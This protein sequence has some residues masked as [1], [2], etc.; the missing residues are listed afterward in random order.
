[1]GAV[2]RLYG[3]TVEQIWSN[4]LTPPDTF[5]ELGALQVTGNHRSASG[6]YS[7]R[8]MD[9]VAWSS[10]KGPD[11][12]L[13][14]SLLLVAQLIREYRRKRIGRH[15]ADLPGR[16]YDFEPLARGRLIF[17][18]ERSHE[19]HAEFFRDGSRRFG[20]RADLDA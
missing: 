7:M 9:D 6:A 15:V 20:L 16:S 3:K 13:V 17:V 5:P 18:H 2:T 1:M 8:H 12:Y 11:D 19:E 10:N 14:S 4:C